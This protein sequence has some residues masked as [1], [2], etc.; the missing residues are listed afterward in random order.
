[1]ASG[2]QKVGSQAMLRTVD[3][4]PAA[5]EDLRVL[6]RNR[7]NR[8]WPELRE[9]SRAA[10]GFDELLLLSR[11][12]KKAETLGALSGCERQEPLRLAI[13][14][15]YSLY[16]LSELIGHLSSVSGFASELFLGRF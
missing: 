6:L 16:P 11:L 8:F 15:G 14:G 9:R 1:M 13:F 4:A 10:A 7:D 12:R 5:T 3:A 2:L